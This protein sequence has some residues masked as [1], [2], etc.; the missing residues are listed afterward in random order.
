MCVC[1]HA[2][3]F[4]AKSIHEVLNLLTATEFLHFTTYTSKWNMQ[5]VMY[6][7]HKDSG[8]DTYQKKFKC[9]VNSVTYLYLNTLH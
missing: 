4:K 3:Y 7:L 8:I 1:I 9:S 5:Y 6:T 2:I